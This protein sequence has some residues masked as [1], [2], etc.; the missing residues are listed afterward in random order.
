MLSQLSNP[1]NRYM[2]A[3]RH[4]VPQYLVVVVIVSLLAVTAI[5]EKSGAARRYAQYSPFINHTGKP[6]ENSALYFSSC[7][8]WAGITFNQVRAAALTCLDARTDRLP[9]P[10]PQFIWW[11]QPHQ[12]MVAEGA[13]GFHQR[14]WAQA[15]MS[16]LGWYY[17]SFFVFL[18]V[19]VRP[20]Y[21][22]QRNLICLG[23]SLFTAGAFVCGFSSVL[24]MPSILLRLVWLYG[25]ALLVLMGSRH[26]EEQHR[27][28]FQLLTQASKETAALADAVELQRVAEGE[29]MLRI[30][31]ES[32]VDAEF[33]LTAFLCHGER[34]ALQY[35]ALLLQKS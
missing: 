7:I 6:S 17:S 21:E 16:E 34:P 27:A 23:S 13:S 11:D 25:T 8:V 5:M 26:S 32:R 28:H 19:V 20:M 4:G 31:A 12:N 30:D 10:P 35:F 18:T 2:Y 9:Q 29:K 24:P 1:A 33:N 15:N 14:A 3:E 22:T